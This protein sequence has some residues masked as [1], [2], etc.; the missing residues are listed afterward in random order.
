MEKDIVNLTKSRY[1]A[2]RLLAYEGEAGPNS[3]TG[4]SAAF[5]VCAKLRQPLI[6]LAGVDGFRSL[7]TRALTLARAEAPSLIAVQVA[8]DG[9]VIGFG[10][11]ASRPEKDIATDEGAVL[12]AYLI[13][14]L[15]TFIG[16]GLTSRLVED[17]WPGVILNGRVSEKE[18]KI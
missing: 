8:A 16:E 5:R 7:L 2:K 1:L 11:F 12:I 6:T 3:V 18:W 13:G 17:V 4:D 14:L 15:V 9:S 10:E